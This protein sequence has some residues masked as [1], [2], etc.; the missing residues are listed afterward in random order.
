MAEIPAIAK[1]NRNKEQGFV[2]RGIDDVYFA[3]NPVFAAHNVFMRAEVLEVKRE[4]RP[5][6][7]GGLLTIV[8]ARVRYHFVTTDGSSL[9][10]ESLGEA[11][12][13]GDKAT[14]K[15]IAI[16]HKYAILQMF[17]IPTAEQKDP[18]FETPEPAAARSSAPP[19]SAPASRL[20]GSAPRPSGPPPAS[21]PAA[22]PAG[23]AALPGSGPAP[24]AAPS[25]IDPKLPISESTATDISDYATAIINDKTET[26]ESLWLRIQNYVVSR[27]GTPPPAVLQDLTEAEGVEVLYRLKMIAA[28]NTP[29]G[30]GK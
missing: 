21:R 22:A 26:E 6:R 4:E 3:V 29:A 2:F 8:Q 23:Q 28:A 19:A 24:A 17:C 7:S 11:M 16:A 14:S 18:D 20:P 10:T 13:S 27:F 15:A 1:T 5:S 12:D 25:P 9:A 30:G